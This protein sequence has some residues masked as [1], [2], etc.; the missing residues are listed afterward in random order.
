MTTATRRIDD[1]ELLRGLA[2]FGILIHHSRGGLLAWSTPALDRF[3]AY[4]TLGHTLDLFFAIS[5]FVIARDLIP[6]VQDSGADRISFFRLAIGFWIRRAYR[7]LPS[8]WICLAGI[9]LLSLL[10]NSSNA[11]G[12]FRSNFAGAVAA[13][14]QVANM[15]YAINFFSE[16]GMGVTYHFWSLSLEEQFYFALPFML[17]F[18]GRAFPWL[19]AALVLAQLLSVRPGRLA[20]Y[21]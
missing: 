16:L 15:H 5:G 6:K 2:V 18:V 8:A 10:F 7:L 19:A 13:T 12:S 20:L 21:P 17:F 3:H 4:F 14:L 11:F 1:I 9:V